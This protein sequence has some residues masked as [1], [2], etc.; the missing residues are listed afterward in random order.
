MVMSS[1]KRSPPSL[2]IYSSRQPFRGIL[3][4][5]QSDYT[6]N[7]NPQKIPR[8]GKIKFL[9]RKRKNQNDQTKTD[10]DDQTNGW[11]ACP[12]PYATS[13]PSIPRLISYPSTTSPF[14]TILQLPALPL[15]QRK[16]HS[17]RWRPAFPSEVHDSPVILSVSNNHKTKSSRVSGVYRVP[18]DPFHALPSA[19]TVVSTTKLY[20]CL[21][22]V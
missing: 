13:H 14:C 1:P 18:N 17:F 12:C 2:F 6:R 7:Q 16:K 5:R 4:G 22:V 11:R 10:Q 8:L 21:V 20:V 3:A 9:R 15:T 19:K